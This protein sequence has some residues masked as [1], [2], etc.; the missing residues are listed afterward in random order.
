VLPR[1]WAGDDV[2]VARDSNGRHLGWGP[3]SYYLETLGA[4]PVPGTGTRLI[5]TSARQV[6]PLFRGG[7]TLN[8]DGTATIWG[9]SVV[10]APPDAPVAMPLQGRIR[11]LVALGLDSV[12]ALLDDGT[13]WAYPGV[14]SPRREPTRMGTPPGGAS[15]V[16][17]GS[18]FRFYF[19]TSGGDIWVYQAT[20]DPPGTGVPAPNVSGVLSVSCG[21]SDCIGVRRDGTVLR[22]DQVS[23]QPRAL[24]GLTDIAQMSLGGSGGTGS[25]KLATQA[26]VSS[27]GQLWVWRRSDAPEAE[28]GFTDVTDVSCAAYYCVIRRA[29]GSVWGWGLAHLSRVRDLLGPNASDVQVTRVPD[30]LVP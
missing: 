11:Q 5:S 8:A 28:P 19:V 9:Q 13:A 30:V 2:V 7:A 14:I 6:I 29:D 27:S 21:S 1:L 25:G 15:A 10:N 18:S 24:A 23:D 4:T 16:A 26:A 17:S 20:Q 12:I 22:W 3:K